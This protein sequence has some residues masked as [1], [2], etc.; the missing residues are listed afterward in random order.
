MSSKKK[1]IHINNK[2]LD[3]KFSPNK[4]EKLKFIIVVVKKGHGVAT[5][6]LMLEEGCSMT[7]NLYGEGTKEKYVMDILGG[8]EKNKECILGLISEK[9]YPSLKER[10]DNRFTISQASKGTLIA[11]DVA[12]MAG[13]LAYKFISDYVGA[14]K[15]GSKK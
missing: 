10:L 1:H 6:E 12:S 11:I 14:K 7:V 15:Y 2:K 8:E 5:N 13:V 9:K 4:L 3:T